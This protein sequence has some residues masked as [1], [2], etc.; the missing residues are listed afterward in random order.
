MTPLTVHTLTKRFSSEGRAAVDRLSF[1][2]GPHEVF[3]LV[4][5]SGCGKTTTLRIIA[6]FERPDAGSVHLGEQI[7]E[8]PG[9]HLPPEKRQIGLVF[10]DYALFP[11]L[12]VLHNV[13][14]GLRGLPRTERRAR[15]LECLAMVGMGDLA[16]RRPHELSGG[17]Q[18]RVAIARSIAPR[19][20]ILL[21]DEP[22]S[23]LDPSLRGETRD[24][25]RDLLHEH[26]MSALL[27][28]HDQEEALSFADRIGVMRHGRVVQAGEPQQ[29]YSHPQSAFVAQFLGRTNL[30]EGDAQ[31]PHAAT[32]IGQVCLCCA[33]Q[34]PVLLSVRPEHL[35][36][37]IPQPGQAVGHVVAR[38]FKGHDLTFRV[39]CG[40]RQYIVQTDYNC[41]FQIGQTVG[42]LHTEPAVA[43]DPNEC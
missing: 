23:N 10:Q 35:R 20:R 12:D 11:H 19:P 17:Q 1:E 39:A 9:V 13:M 8:G 28:T 25:I 38:E 4:G 26:G 34:G 6:G 22:F 5:P 2:V 7:I 21:L 15:A 41:P 30:I 14:F 27:V 29:V 33:A 18:Q 40:E 3:A 36:L 24:Q 32:A 43:V 16:A 31:G 42:L 37:T